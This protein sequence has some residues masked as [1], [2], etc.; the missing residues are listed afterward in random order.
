MRGQPNE[1]AFIAHTCEFLARLRGVS[2]DDFAELTFANAE[3]VLEKGE[4]AS[5]PLVEK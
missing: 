3:R 4:A 5:S 2:A 1:P